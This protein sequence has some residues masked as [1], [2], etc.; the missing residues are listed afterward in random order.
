MISSSSA[1]CARAGAATPA[2]P[3]QTAE[4]KSARFKTCI[5]FPLFLAR[6]FRPTHSRHQAPPYACAGTVGT[7]RIILYFEIEF[8]LIIVE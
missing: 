3:T 7:I 1:D 5:S 8:K 6:R 2:P 4:H